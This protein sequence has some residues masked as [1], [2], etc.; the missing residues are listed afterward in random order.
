MT[1]TRGLVSSLVAV[2]LLLGV[3]TGRAAGNPIALT[4][5]RQLGVISD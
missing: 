4:R 2:Y 3:G 5:L 1:A